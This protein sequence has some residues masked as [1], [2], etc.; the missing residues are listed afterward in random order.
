MTVIAVPIMDKAG[1]R[2]LILYPMIIMDVI[3]IVITTALN[4]QRN[5][6][7]HWMSYVSIVCVIG[8]VICFAIG[9]GPIP[10]MIAAE[11]FRQG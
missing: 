4:L 10:V 1:R 8:Y 3:L 2:P 5:Q 9:L 6:G 7:I 11:L